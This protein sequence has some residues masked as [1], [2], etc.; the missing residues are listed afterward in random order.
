MGRP[1]VAVVGRPN[2]GKSTFFNK[3]CGKRISIVQDEPG[4]TRDRIYGDAEWCG[5]AFSLVDTGGIDFVEKGEI[6]SN[7]IMQARI[8]VDLAQ[9]ILFFVDGKEG[10]TGADYE[11]ADFLRRSSKPIVLVVNKLDNYEVENSYEF[12]SLNCG[13]PYPISAEH[14]KG[15]GDVLDVIVNHLKESGEKYVE[16]DAIKIAVVGKPNAGKSSLTNKILNDDRMLVTSIAGTTRDAIDTPFTFN[17]EDFVIIDTAGM[18]KKSVIEEGSVESYSVLRS[19]DAIR[20]SDVCLLVIDATQGVSDQDL[21]IASF[22]DSEGKP[23]VVVINKWDLVEKDHRTMNE[24]NKILQK[25]FDFMTYIKPV[26]ISAKSGQRVGDV[27]PLV[28]EVYENACRKIPMGVLNEIVGDAVGATP[29]PSKGG[30][31]L[32]IIYTVQATTCPPK[33]LFF[34]QNPELIVPSYE[35]Y[36]ENKLRLAFN[37]EGTPIK[38]LFRNKNDKD[39]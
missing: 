32:K 18:R 26:Y 15:V 33:F 35:K 14:G 23:L 37:F 39:E 25:E 5:Y 30:N 21:K 11:V 20:R 29:P 3:V 16:T 19:I 36:L 4:V 12:Y 38:L 6:Q 2:V 24:F 8:A 7:I 31:R 27:L 22:I 17:G 13:D 34:C 1:L 10:L 9:V 28:K